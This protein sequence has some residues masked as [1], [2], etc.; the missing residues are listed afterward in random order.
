MAHTIA[1]YTQLKKLYN[2]ITCEYNS[3]IIIVTM[4]GKKFKFAETIVLKQ[5]I[6]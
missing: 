6:T 1:I 2:G 5:A 4:S 3:Y